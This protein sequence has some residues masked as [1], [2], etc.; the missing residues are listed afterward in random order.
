MS[1]SEA[2]AAPTPS[3]VETVSRFVQ[4][5]QIVKV[6]LTPEQ[7]QSLAV[8][9]WETWDKE[10]GGFVHDYEIDEDCYFDK[11]K[12]I[13]TAEGGEPVTIEVG[14]FITFPAGLR[15]D[16]QIVED[17]SKHWREYPRL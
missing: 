16:W 17:V 4:P 1:A 10:V 8:A 14:D 13:C 9:G 3:P 2:V 15:V 11:G 6:K 7:Y 5:G 12:A